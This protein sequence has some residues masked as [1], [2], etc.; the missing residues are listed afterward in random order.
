MNFVEKIAIKSLMPY[1]VDFDH[2]LRHNQR[3]LQ[4]SSTLPIENDGIVW[5]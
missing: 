1:N 5:Q 4:S 2:N 3:I